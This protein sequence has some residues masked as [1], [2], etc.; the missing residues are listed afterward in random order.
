MAHI[1]AHLSLEELEKRYRAAQDAT[2]ARHLQAIWLLA[3]GRAV[4]EVADV[5]AFVPRW[6]EALAARYNVH[7]LITPK[8]AR[9]RVESTPYL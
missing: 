9:K 8:S 4:L 1:V 7:S 3:Q 6:V 5:L 2:E